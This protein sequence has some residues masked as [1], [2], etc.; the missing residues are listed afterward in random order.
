MDLGII[1]RKTGEDFGDYKPKKK[2]KSRDVYFL[3]FFENLKKSDF[4]LMQDTALIIG[5]MDKDNVLCLSTRT[6]NYLA[7]AMETTVH[8]VNVRISALRFRHILLKMSPG[9]YLVDPH[10]FTKCNTEKLEQLRNRF[11]DLLRE[12]IAKERRPKK[13]KKEKETLK[14]VI[15]QLQAEK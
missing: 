14:L 6:R 8:A 15:H 11:N 12:T 13:Q 3:T 4:D 5:E 10:L 9:Q 7:K 1:D 2:S